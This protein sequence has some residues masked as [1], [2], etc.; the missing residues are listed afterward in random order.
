MKTASL[1]HAI[2]LSA[3]SPKSFSENSRFKRSASPEM[4]EFSLEDLIS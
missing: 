3:W 4:E 2:S 1:D